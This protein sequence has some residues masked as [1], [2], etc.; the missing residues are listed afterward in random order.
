MR[1]L[2]SL[3]ILL[4]AVVVSLQGQMVIDTVLVGN[5]GSTADT[6]PYGAVGFNY[7]IGKH[8]VTN[9]QYAQFLESWRIDKPPTPGPSSRRG[10]GL[11]SDPQNSSPQ[12][13]HPA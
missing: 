2:V 8:E 13:Y 6:P 1:K 3:V 7:Y 10:P 5:A 9:G 12:S 11:P 4:G